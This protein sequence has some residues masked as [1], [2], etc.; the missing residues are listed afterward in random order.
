MTGNANT[1]TDAIKDLWISNCGVEELYITADNGGGTY[2]SI[3]SNTFLSIS[4][5]LST[6][7]YT[8]YIYTV[9]AK[10]NGQNSVFPSTPSLTVKV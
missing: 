6:N 3:T 9:T 4:Y 5:K 1:G 10:L 2:A 8:E 7:D